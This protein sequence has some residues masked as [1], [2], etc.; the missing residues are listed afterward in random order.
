MRRRR[1]T[2][3]TFLDLPLFTS[4]FLDPS[5]GF[6]VGWNFFYCYSITIPVELVASSLVIQYWNATINQA[7]W[8]TPLFFLIVVVNFMPVQWYGEME[9]WFA[10]IK[11]VAIVGLM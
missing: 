8:I 7:A 4:R 6:A 9:F 3:L 11:I 5:L 2:K 10:A 1:R